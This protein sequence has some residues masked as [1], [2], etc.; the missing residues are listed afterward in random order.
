MM[1]DMHSHYIPEKFI[2][3]IQK[4]DKFMAKTNRVDGELF[5][6]HEQGYTYP[7]F[8]EFHDES[9][10]LEKMEKLGIDLSILSPA[11]PMFYYWAEDEITKFM[12]QLVNDELLDFTMK[13][14]EKFKMMATIPMNNVKNAIDELL[15]IYKKSDGTLRFVEIGTNIEGKLLNDPEFY[16]FF[17]KV[18]ELNITL[19]LHPYY[20][21]KK[22][23]LQNYYLTNLVGNPYDTTLSAANLIFSGFMNRFKNLK[24]ILS[25]GG[26]F[27][28][29]QIGR[30]QHGH[31]VREETKSIISDDPIDLLKK[32]YFDTITFN[33][34]SLAF[35][36]RLVGSEHIVY[37]TDFPFDMADY[38]TFGD[39]TE[40]ELSRQEKENILYK[41]IT[42]MM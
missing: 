37:G 16:P 7:F 35:L 14:P 2:N 23:G 18:E 27:L 25:H 12:S 20:I 29:Y 39:H 11:P 10:K 36:N 5:I 34:K 22:H 9:I 28:P 30:L 24:I 3:L 40:K 42:T 19:L 8:S 26:G 15:R 38:S 6:A 31:R 13:A 32:F 17:E 4:S 21:G 41:N 1:I 33:D